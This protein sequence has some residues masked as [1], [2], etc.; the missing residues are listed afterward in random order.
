MTPSNT[1]YTATPYWSSLTKLLAIRL[2]GVVLVVTYI[3]S[4]LEHFHGSFR[5]TE[6]EVVV[7]GVSDEKKASDNVD[8]CCR[9]GQ[10]KL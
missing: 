4:V 2:V 7:L 9:A 1:I 8:K 5:L 6:M 3:A 10:S